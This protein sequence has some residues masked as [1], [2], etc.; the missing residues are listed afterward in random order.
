MTFLQQT[1][2]RNYKWV[3]FTLFNMRSQLAYLSGM[4]GYFIWGILN[5]LGSILVWQ[6][7]GKYTGDTSYT[8]YFWFLNLY[9]GMA[10]CWVVS[11]V[12]PEI[13]NGSF[14]KFLLIPTHPFSYQ[15]TN[16]IGRGIFV[17]SA[18]MTFFNLMIGILLSSQLNFK[19]DF[20]TSLLLIFSIPIYYFINFTIQWIVSL[21]TF[22]TTD[23]GPNLAVHEIVSDYLIGSKFPLYLVGSVLFWQP[24]AFMG[25]NQTMIALGKYSQAEIAQ[26]FII[27]LIWC[28]VL[29]ILARF[30]FKAGLKKNEA[31]GL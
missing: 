25:H 6:I 29:S 2:G 10:V 19:L 22:W 9:N 31:V 14:T 30:V 28:I 13:K 20:G 1:L 17:Y 3:Y 27:G 18:I 7:I 15:F 5:T 11:S 23:F 24:F 12:S 8:S 26:T 16:F 21:V 4:W